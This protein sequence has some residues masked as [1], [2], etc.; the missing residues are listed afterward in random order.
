VTNEA[1]V[2]IARKEI[3]R[4]LFGPFTNNERVNI[5]FQ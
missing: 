3:D 4:V 1:K 5:K 2:W